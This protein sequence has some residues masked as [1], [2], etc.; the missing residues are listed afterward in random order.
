M[1]TCCRCNSGWCL[2]HESNLE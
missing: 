1:S 2:F